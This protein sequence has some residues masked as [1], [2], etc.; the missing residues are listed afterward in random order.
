MPMKSTP[1]RYG[2]VAMAL[3]WVTALMI[4]LLLISGFLS[5]A[6]NVAEAKVLLLAFHVPI[7]LA[8]L[9]MT[10]LRLVWWAFVDRKPRSVPGL[11]GLAR[12]VHVV[13][14]LTIFV[15]VASGIGT[16]LLSQAGPIIFAGDPASLPD[17]QQFP[18][19]HL[20]RAVA[21]AIVALVGGHGAAA[22]FHQVIRRDG[23]MTR[24]LPGRQ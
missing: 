13:L 3:H 6:S 21:I 17:F 4:L 23:V 19:R 16:V 12:L 11:P 15:A 5:G 18:P 24:I 10:L 1:E 20:H 9:G 14:Y 7:G 2:H 22:L 8:V